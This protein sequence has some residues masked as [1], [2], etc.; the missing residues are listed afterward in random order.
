MHRLV[1]VF[2][3][4]ALAAGA[5]TF[6]AWERCAGEGA[7]SV[8]VLYVPWAGYAASCAPCENVHGGFEGELMLQADPAVLPHLPLRVRIRYSGVQ[9]DEIVPDL[10]HNQ[11]GAVDKIWLQTRGGCS[12]QRMAAAAHPGGARTFATNTSFRVRSG[13]MI[14]ETLAET[15]IVL[16]AL[17]SGLGS[18]DFG[19][20]GLRQRFQPRGGLSVLVARYEVM[21]AAGRVL[22]RGVVPQFAG[23]SYREPIADA[24]VM[25]DVEADRLL[26]ER[27]G[28]NTV[29]TVTALPQSP[30]AYEGL[31]AIW[32]SQSVWES[33][34]AEPRFWQR[35]LLQGV[36]LYGRP[37]T[38]QAMQAVL[39]PGSNGVLLAAQLAAPAATAA[40]AHAAPYAAAYGRPG[41]LD[42]TCDTNGVMETGV[43]ENVCPLFADAVQYRAWTIGVLGLFTFGTVVLLA[44]AFLRLPGPRRMTLWWALP[45]W[46]ALFALLGGGVGRWVL[47]RQARAD[48]TEYRYAHVNWPEM[49][50][51]AVGRMLRFDGRE[52][53]WQLPRHAVECL[54]PPAYQAGAAP[55]P[56][57]R[58]EVRSSGSVRMSDQGG[59][60]GTS[61][62][63]SAS[64]FRSNALP[65]EVVATTSGRC[66]RATADLAAV[67]V[68]SEKHWH[69]LGAMAAGR[70]A[71][72]RASKATRMDRLPGLPLA[73]AGCWS[74]GVAVNSTDC[75]DA[76]VP[77]YPEPAVSG[78]W[79]VV[80]LQRSEPAMRPVDAQAK[81][82][83][84]VVWMVQCP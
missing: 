53:A 12:T 60:P 46:A 39:D 49:Y 52:C 2:C 42:L 69:S 29:E 15:E 7:G 30:A 41:G 14:R 75:N 73:L 34:A 48:V 82:V 54:H 35:R 77:N 23:Y 62:S 83:G 17:E 11:N 65:F 27:G 64:W 37:E 36:S 22:A 58:Q 47:A 1:G 80:A 61:D 76:P 25:G 68:W 45:L 43:L 8:S 55:R 38:V 81:T 56:T 18:V 32:V 74:K 84:R 9:T 78:T 33:M 40:Q 59:S 67:Y 26:R 50:C 71:G 51:Q 72:L 16:P 21:D 31:R 44:L 13:T 5:E 66:L 19:F 70:E 4:A 57:I 24:W 10:G 6:D 3:L 79:L 63:I 28:L 20:S